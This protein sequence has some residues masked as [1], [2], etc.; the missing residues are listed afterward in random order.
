MATERDA[1]TM[2]EFAT[3]RKIKIPTRGENRVGQAEVR[4]ENAADEA[5]E[6]AAM[7]ADD[8]AT[9]GLAKLLGE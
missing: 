2:Q 7:E 9:G 8:F 3:G 4:M 5:A 6:R 1:R